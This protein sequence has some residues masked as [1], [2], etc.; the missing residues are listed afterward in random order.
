MDEKRPLKAEGD[1]LRNEALSDDP[2]RRIAARAAIAPGGGPKKFCILSRKPLGAIT[3]VPRL[4]KELSDHGYDVSVLSMGEP[5][6]ELRA[7]TPDVKYYGVEVTPFTRPLM[8]KF[9]RRLVK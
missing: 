2:P 5:V 4:A 3:R 1:S 9:E 8:L 6:D 7:T